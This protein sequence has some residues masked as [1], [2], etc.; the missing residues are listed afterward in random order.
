MS[1]S[2]RGRRC[3]P[4]EVT[5]SPGP[6]LRRGSPEQEAISPIHE[7]GIRSRSDPRRP[8]VEVAYRTCG[9]RRHVYVDDQRPI[10]HAL[11]GV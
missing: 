10:S 3:P 7:T 11:T 2:A 8:R 6:P 1:R 4:A 5:V 9:R